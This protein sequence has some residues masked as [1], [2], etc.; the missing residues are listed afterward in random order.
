MF[1]SIEIP[2]DNSYSTYR[3]PKGNGKFRV[4]TAPSEELK[5]FQKLFM[6][7]LESITLHSSAH[8]FVKGRSISTNAFPHIK[9]KFVLSM[10][11]KDFFPSIKTDM[12]KGIFSL[13]N[14][15]QKYV[16]FVTYKGG[17]PQGSPCSPVISNIYCYDLDVE[18][19]FY[20]EKN[21]LSYTRYADDLTFSGKIFDKK[22][23]KEIKEIVNRHKLKVHP[24]KTKVMWQNQRQIVTGVIV[25][26]K[27]NMPIEK[28]KKM[29]ALRH[30]FDVLPKK[31]RR[32]LA[33]LKGF[34]TAIDNGRKYMEGKNEG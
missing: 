9:K 8:G 23:I 11:L 15:D 30:Q 31:E 3:I 13:H 17:L 18:L 20:S 29:R 21:N 16:E 33:G 34:G 5:G 26:E 6:E 12:I 19:S 25:N 2:K 7:H 14:I 28:R 22:Y 10:D 32:V 27:L 24:N 1:S 4:I